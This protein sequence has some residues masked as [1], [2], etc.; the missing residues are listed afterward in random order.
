MTGKLTDYFE[1]KDTAL[2]SKYANQK[3]PIGLLHDAYFDGRADLKGDVLE[4]LTH[5]R[6]STT[7]N[8]ITPD[9]VKFAVTKLLPEV[10]I[11][12]KAQ[13]QRIVREHYDRGNDFFQAFLGDRMVYTGA[14]FRS[15]EDTLEKAQDQKMDM[16]CQKLLMKEGDRHLDIG[17][18]WGTLVAHA[19]RYYGTDSTGV[20]IAEEQ[21]K[22]GTEAIERYGVSSR[23][24]IKCIDYRD[25]PNEKWDKVT[26]LEMAE[27]VGSKNFNKFMRQVYGLLKDDG[28]FYL[29]IVGPKPG[30]RKENTSFGLFMSKYIFPG[31]DASRRIT[32]TIEH[33][34]DAGFEIHSIEN[35]GMHYSVTLNRWYDNWLVNK[36][37]IIEKYGEGWFRLWNFFLAWATVV[38]KEGQSTGWQIVCNKNLRTLDRSVFFQA[39][40]L[41]EKD[42]PARRPKL[43]PAYEVTKEVERLEHPLFAS[44]VEEAKAASK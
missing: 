24:R 21:T 14:F 23:A 9:H 28:L 22:Y 33:L 11:H 3:I 30:G 40:S 43:S 6:D 5:H 7:I 29:Q 27:H 35:I 8:K 4:F 39:P 42:F 20:T 37:A 38:A 13:D 17:S 2:A 44:T 12:S 26:C 32:W 1:F 34:E 16:V 10:V 18:G 25:I 41:G 15:I 36:D 31:A 19:A